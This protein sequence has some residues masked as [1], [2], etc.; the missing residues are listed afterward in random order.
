MK[1]ETIESRSGHQDIGSTI[2]IE[3]QGRLFKFYYHIDESYHW[4]SRAYLEVMS[5]DNK[6]THLTSVNVWDFEKSRGNEGR[7]KYVEQDDLIDFVKD[8]V[9]KYSKYIAK[10]E[11]KK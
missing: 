8:L 10:T 3:N 1:L 2:L 5:T 6:F 9:H 7:I 4:Q 11:Q